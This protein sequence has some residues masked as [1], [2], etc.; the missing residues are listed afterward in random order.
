M[1]VPHLRN[2]NLQKGE[3]GLRLGVLQDTQ[4]EGKKPPW[5]PKITVTGDVSLPDIYIYAGLDMF[6]IDT[7]T[8]GRCT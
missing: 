8:L 5:K 7:Q 4:A 1:Q 2:I 6:V 3:I